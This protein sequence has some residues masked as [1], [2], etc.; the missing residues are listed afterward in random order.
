MSKSLSPSRQLAAKVIHAA[1]K[2]L[3]EKGGE[4]PSKEVI[5]EIEK[6]VHLDDW[7]RSIYEKTGYVRWKSILHFYLKYLQSSLHHQSRNISGNQGQQ[8][9][10]IPIVG[11]G[12]LSINLVFISPYI[13]Q[14]KHAI[15]TTI[16]GNLN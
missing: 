10:S 8:G 5:E 6:T 2:I 3:H 4:A 13:A 15:H 9:L 16:L 14:N 11:L 7:A 12:F 1:I